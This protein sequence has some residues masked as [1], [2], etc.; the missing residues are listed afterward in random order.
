MSAAFHPDAGSSER[1]AP[2]PI[3]KGRAIEVSSAQRDAETV[4]GI[5]ANDHSISGAS[6][7]IFELRRRM[8]MRRKAGHL[9]Y[10]CTRPLGEIFTSA[11]SLWFDF[12][13]NVWVR[14]HERRL[15]RPTC[16]KTGL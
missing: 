10:R 14:W 13:P 6:A 11:D 9:A 4:F 1:S 5:G 12:A 15:L 3:V 2:W 7:K 16:W 8:L